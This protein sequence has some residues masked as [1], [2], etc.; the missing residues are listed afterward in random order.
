MAKKLIKS[1]KRIKS[2]STSN[3]SI[4]WLKLK[5]KIDEEISKL[6]CT[7]WANAKIIFEINESHSGTQ[8]ID[9][10]LDTTN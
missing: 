8:I 9:I 6:D 4:D 3:N 1:K 2:I 7:Q 10:F 5:V